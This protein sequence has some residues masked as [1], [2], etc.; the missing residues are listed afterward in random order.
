[1]I[2]EFGIDD[3]LYEMAIKKKENI[4]YVNETNVIDV[5][6]NGFSKGFFNTCVLTDTI[7]SEWPNIEFYYNSKKANKG[8]DGLGNIE[9]WPVIHKNVM[10]RFKEM[11]IKGV[12]YYPI[13]L[14]DKKTGSINN[15]YVLMYIRNF[16]EAYDMEKSKYNYIEKLN[17][18]IFEPHGIVMKQEESVNYDIFRCNKFSSIIYVSQRVRD[19][20]VSNG[21][22]G[23]KTSETRG[24][25]YCE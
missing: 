13:K 3:V 17:V 4:I 25:R 6:C 16:I 7:F 11:E 21:W 10:D 1:M 15:D 12:E 2:Y 24:G 18:Y 23:L 5:E 14:V 9:S 8:L 19:E 22:T 20:I